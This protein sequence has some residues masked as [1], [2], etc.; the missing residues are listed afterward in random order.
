MLPCSLAYIFICIE[1][2]IMFDMNNDK[3][4][5][6]NEGIRKE[7][8]TFHALKNIFPVFFNGIDEPS[9]FKMLKTKIK[10]KLNQII[11]LPLY[12]CIN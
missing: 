1:L 2:I 5:N 10:R 9:Y 3:S 6:D 4:K 12:I 11:Q 8:E 7:Y